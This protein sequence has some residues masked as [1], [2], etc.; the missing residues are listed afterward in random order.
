[1][2]LLFAAKS[3]S[4][5]RFVY[6]VNVFQNVFQIVVSQRRALL[7]FI[8]VNAGEVFQKR[9]LFLY[10]VTAR[11]VSPSG[12]HG[13]QPCPTAHMSPAITCYRHSTTCRGRHFYLC[14]KSKQWLYHGL[15]YYWFDFRAGAYFLFSEHS[16]PSLGSNQPHFQWVLVTFSALVTQPRREGKHAPL[17]GA[18]HKNKW[19]FTTIPLYGFLGLFCVSYGVSWRRF[20][21]TF[22]ISVHCVTGALWSRT[23]ANPHFT[24]GHLQFELLY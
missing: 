10:V 8:R 9:T 2:L 1:M 6:E 23:K 12:P 14:P 24:A 13:V 21:L 17:S 7:R 4:Y 11:T 22:S 18:K 19:S 3:L 5:S 20:D 15:E 16:I